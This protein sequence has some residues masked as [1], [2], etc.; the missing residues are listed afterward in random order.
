M[1]FEV[2]CFLVDEKELLEVD[3]LVIYSLCHECPSNYVAEM[4]LFE[5]NVADKIE[6]TF[7]TEYTIGWY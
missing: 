1:S 7:K 3:I 6:N 2:S 5:R 4:L